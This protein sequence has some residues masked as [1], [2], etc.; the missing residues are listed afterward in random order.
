MTV[1]EETQ[2]GLPAG[3]AADRRLLRRPSSGRR[4]VRR[5]PRRARPEDRPAQVALPAG[6]PRHLGHGHPVRAD[7]DGPHRRR[8]RRSRRSASR[9]SRAGSTRSIASPASRC[10]RS[11]S[12]RSRKATCP[13]SGIRRRSRSSPSRRHTTVRA[14]SID[15]LIDFTPELQAEGGEARRRATR[16]GRSSRRRSSASGTARS[17]TLM[18]PNAT[19]GANWQGG[20][21]DP[22]TK[23]FYIFTNTHADAA[24]TGEARIRRDRTSTGCRARRAIR[25]RRPGRSRR[26]AATAPA[27]QVAAGGG[28]APRSPRPARQI[29]PAGGGGAAAVKAAATSRFRACRSSSRRTDASRR[30]T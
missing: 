27:R 22:E 17:A 19:G 9:P 11:K 30:S 13:A 12:G 10:G 23:M 21:F 16:S 5:E 8:P 14:S 15:D 1:D 18:L 20:A 24:R 4:S 3:G 7:P 26:R 25:T 28:G 6:A 29:P 2:H